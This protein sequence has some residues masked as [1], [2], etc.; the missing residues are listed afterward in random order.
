MPSEVIDH[1]QQL[2]GQRPNQ[3]TDPGTLPASQ[4]PSDS[5]DYEFVPE[6]EQPRREPERDVK[7]ITENL[8]DVEFDD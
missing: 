6:N 1:L 8:A 4:L 5:P 3:I 2:Y 7:K